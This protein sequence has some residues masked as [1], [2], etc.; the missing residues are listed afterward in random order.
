[1]ASF[2]FNT[3]SD[4]VGISSS[5]HLVLI[6]QLSLTHR[7]GKHTELSSKFSCFENQYHLSHSRQ[8]HDTLPLCLLTLRDRKPH[9][10]P[11]TFQSRSI[12]L[13]DKLR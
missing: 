9:L 2:A 4:V 8:T 11:F 13:K 10:E 5:P 12:I 1:M 3:Y 7:L 6:Q